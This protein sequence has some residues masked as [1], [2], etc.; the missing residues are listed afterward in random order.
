[1]ENL[2]KETTF[3][4]FGLC[5]VIKSA[6]SLGL[7]YSTATQNHLHWVLALAQTPNATILRWVIPTCWYLKTLKLTLPPTQNIKLTLPPTQ[8]L[9]TSQWNIACV[10]SPTQN[11]RIGHVHFMLFVLISFTFVTQCEPSLQWD[12]GFR[13]FLGNP[14]KCGF[15]V[16]SQ[17]E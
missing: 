10:G 16:I 11:F 3:K 2:G 5:R 14:W 9:N 15:Q 13:V 6:S 4:P 1:M 8:N 7:L 17:R 12:M